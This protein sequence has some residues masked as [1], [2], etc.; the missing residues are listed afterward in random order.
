MQYEINDFKLRE[1]TVFA[2]LFWFD[3]D[4]RG[5]FSEVL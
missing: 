5:C 4:D 1:M 2:L 3:N